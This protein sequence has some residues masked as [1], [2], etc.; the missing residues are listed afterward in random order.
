MIDSESPTEAPRW[1]SFWNKKV[2]PLTKDDSGI[3]PKENVSFAA[4]VSLPVKRITLLPSFHF[5][6]FIFLPLDPRIEVLLSPS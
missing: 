6:F 4:G 2:E 1:R 5:Y 3:N